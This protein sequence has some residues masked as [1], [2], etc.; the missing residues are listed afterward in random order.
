MWVYTVT[1]FSAVHYFIIVHN[2]FVYAGM[3]GRGD[4]TK[5]S[6]RIN[7]TWTSSPLPFPPAL[8]SPLSPP[9][10]VL[11]NRVRE[12]SVVISERREEATG[13]R[14]RLT[15]LETRLDDLRQH[16][17]EAR[18]KALEALDLVSRNSF[19][20]TVER[21]NDVSVS[22]DEAR[23]RR[24]QQDEK[25]MIHTFLGCTVCLYC[26]DEEAVSSSVAIVDLLVLFR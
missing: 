17:S 12:F 25:K 20:G 15:D 3:Y 9:S 21:V 16:S 14:G 13:L 18:D 24:M 4:Y 26:Y 2:Y 23:G 11:L 5:C 19:Q 1:C 7:V 6:S 8:S 10:A 22:I